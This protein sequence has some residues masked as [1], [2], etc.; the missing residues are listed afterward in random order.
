MAGR[1][2]N[3]QKKWLEPLQEQC[4]KILADAG[5]QMAKAIGMSLYQQ[6]QSLGQTTGAADFSESGSSTR[7]GTRAQHAKAGR[8]GGKARARKSSN[9]IGATTHTS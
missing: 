9:G 7:G 2:S 8:A 1:I 4:S 3:E 6:Q 5:T